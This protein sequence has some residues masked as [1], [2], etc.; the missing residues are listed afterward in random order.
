MKIIGISQNIKVT[1]YNQLEDCLDQNLINLLN[2]CGF[3]P[4]PIPNNLID[5]SNNHNLIRFL[6]KIPFSGFLLS[7][8]NDWGS[9]ENRDK[10]EINLIEYSIKKS[11]PI[12][13]IC[14]GMQVI[15]HWAGVGLKRVKGHVNTKHIVRG[16]REFMV[17]SYHNFSI[18]CCPKNFSI[19]AKSLDGEIEAIRHSKYNLE[20]WMWHPERETDFKLQDIKNIKRLFN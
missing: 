9:F 15:A 7:G 10:T 2:L 11:F 20:G 16:K 5:K 12:L 1:Y 4:I 18:K 8:G 19:I 13:G 3:L 14:R 6:E 17:N